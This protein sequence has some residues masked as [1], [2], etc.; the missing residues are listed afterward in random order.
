MSHAVTSSDPV[1]AVE[2]RFANAN[3]LAPAELSPAELSALPQ[4]APRTEST[5]IARKPWIHSPAFDLFFVANLFWPGFLLVGLLQNKTL[6]DSLGFWMVYMLI[7]PHRWITLG[8]VFLDKER[9]VE[10]RGLFMGIAVVA[11]AFIVLNV[12]TLSTL[13]FLLV[14]DYMWNAWHFAAQRSG[15]GR[16]YGRIADPADTRNP[17]WEKLV[18]RTFCVYVIL[19]LG[20]PLMADDRSI[21]LGWLDAS[22]PYLARFDYPLLALPAWIL[23]RELPRCSR[24]ALG[25]LAYL[26]SVSRVVFVAVG[27]GAPACPRHRRHADHRRPA[28]RGHRVSFDRISGHRHVER[29]ETSRS[30]QGR[31]AARARQALGRLAGLLHAGPWRGGVDDQ[32]PFPTRMD[33]DQHVRLVLALRLRWDH[34]E[35]PP[36]GEADSASGVVSRSSANIRS[37]RTSLRRSP[38]ARSRRL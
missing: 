29:Q 9:Y 36:G 2:A 16:I 30:A 33:D 13:T 4:T 25:R 6:D 23:L 18:L 17:F 34:L 24:T 22:I 7:T 19:R 15:I 28:D 37:R 26:G 31:R 3:S 35:G 11:A 5:P 32:R 21:Y 12:L 27:D 10:R 8:L 38:N 20:A 1:A 14:F